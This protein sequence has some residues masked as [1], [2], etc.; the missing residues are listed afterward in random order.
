[1]VPH[2]AIVNHAAWMRAL[3]PVGTDDA[4][5]QRTASSFDASL[6]EIFLPLTA[7]ARLVLARPGGQRDLDY[8]ARLMTD[9]RVTLAVFVPS[10]LRALLDEPALSGCTR[11]RRVLSGGEALPAS[12]VSRFQERLPAAEVYNFYGPTEAAVDVSWF[13]CASPSSAAVVPIGLPIADTRL[14]VLDRRLD[15]VPVGVAGELHVGGV[16]LARGYWRRADLTAERFVPDPFGG[17]PGARLYR[18]GDL[19]RR[20]GDG[21]LEVLGRVDFQV[22][23]RGFRIELAEIEAALA[24]LPTVREAVVVVR[25]DTPGDQR[26]VAYLVADG[27]APAAGDLRAALAARL[28]EPMIPAAYVVL[29]A[30]PLSPSGKVDRAALPAPGP[31]AA[32]A[33]ADVAPRTPI[34]QAVAAIFAEVLKLPAP[35]VGAHDG[36]FDLGGHSLL[37]TQAVSRIRAALGVDL[38]LRA[39][40]EAPA[41]ADLAARI[42]A[43]RD[44]GHGATAAPPVTAVPRDGELPLS[45]GQERLWFLAQLDPRSPAY[46]ISFALRLRGDLDVAA[47]ERTL[48]EVV[49]RHEVLR[50]TFHAEGGKPVPVIHA[51]GPFPLA[52]TSLTTLP[53]DAREQAVR[54]EADAEARRP[55][56]L[57]AGPVIRARLLDVADADHVLLVALHHIASDAWTGALLDREITALYA[58]FREGAPSPLPDLAL[59]YVDY[60]AWQR[61]R[62]SGDTLRTQLDYWKAQ[63]AGAPPALELPTDRPRPVACRRRAVG[64]APSPSR[65]SSPPASRSWPGARAPRST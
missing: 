6:T 63:L 28:P 59:Q 33:R 58:A 9:E 57:A 17:A 46:V 14:H 36:F 65:R 12:L 40:F 51:P 49:R 50:T 54:A 55:F 20:R 47:L 11:L 1:M 24:A 52:R 31:G 2:R 44:A 45:F 35:Q 53:A 29:S 41:V 61:R 22:K 25:E 18:T 16:C 21:V 10:L 8:L 60:A 37:A 56:D 30:L 39:L 26:L 48:A 13:D 23:L 7:G 62:L 32:T 4:M 5:L 34:E 42:E 43:S 15:R 38:P 27:D 19:C 3:W 64:S